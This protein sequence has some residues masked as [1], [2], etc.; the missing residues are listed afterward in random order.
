MQHIRDS[1]TDE[2]ILFHYALWRNSYMPE[3]A[4]RVGE[5]CIKYR[6]T[7]NV[8]TFLKVHSKLDLL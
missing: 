1:L 5:N 4:Q 6:C 7:E 3:E 2:E 8:K